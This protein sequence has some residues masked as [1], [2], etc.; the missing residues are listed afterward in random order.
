MPFPISDVARRIGLEE[1]DVEPFGWHAG[2]LSLG[3]QERL[4]DGQGELRPSSLGDVR[5][6]FNG[7]A[8]KEPSTLN[9][10]NSLG[11][12]QFRA[13]D[14]PKALATLVQVDGRAPARFPSRAH[15]LLDQ[16]MC[17]E[18][19]EDTEKAQPPNNRAQTFRMQDL[20][21]KRHWHEASLLVEE[22]EAVMTSGAL[23]VYS[24]I[25]ALVAGCL[26]ESSTCCGEPDS[27]M[28]PDDMT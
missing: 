4:A 21:R 16:T 20:H 22:V 1:T 25:N 9:H 7:P 28:M 2:K 17:H 6:Q 27:A 23:S 24:A 19:R 12:A 5:G 13:G 11:A 15:N 18:K 10:L 26:G 3:L 14:I 8:K